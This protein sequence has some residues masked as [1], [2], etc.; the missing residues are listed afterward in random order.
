[1]PLR[2][3]IAMR[4]SSVLDSIAGGPGLDRRPSRP[5]ARPTRRF[6]KSMAV[7]AP[8]ALGEIAPERVAAARGHAAA[9]LDRPRALAAELRA[10]RPEPARGEVQRVLV[11]EPDRAVRLVREP[12]ALAGR[13]AHADL[14]DRGLEARVASVRRAK[15]ELRRDA[16]R[17][18][19]AGHHGEI[20]LDGLEARDRTPE[21]LALGGVADGLV[22]A[23]LEGAGHLR[24]ALH[25]AGDAERVAL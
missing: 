7:R 11:G 20:V 3:T 24:R 16:G 21:L 9:E 6:A 5:R 8:S 15:R 10:P 12:R 25:R 2:G 22:E 19:V 17:G 18:D 14:G 23:R 4:I 1:M 13:L